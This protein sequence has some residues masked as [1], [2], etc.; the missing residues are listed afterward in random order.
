MFPT[1]M[2]K[3]FFILFLS[4]SFCFIGAQ[5]VVSYFRNAY[6]QGAKYII[7]KKNPEGED[8]LV[9]EESFLQV[10]FWPALIINIISFILL[11]FT[12]NSFPIN[13]ICMGLF[14]FTD[15]ITLGLVLMTKDENLGVRV[16]WLTAI[17]TLFA[18]TIGLYSNVDF[19]FLGNIL[20]WALIAFIIVSFV[21]IFVRIKGFT[22]K[23]IALIGIV[24]FVGY[25]LYDFNNLRKIRKLA[26][27]NTWNVALDCS[28]DIYLDI[29]NL[30]L[31]ILDLLSDD[32]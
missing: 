26:N 25:L 2:S 1:L 5:A 10:V 17:V 8:D 7:A 21:R 16:A 22:R 32:N 11:M 24:I 18:G 19:S 3:T 12:R 15:G 4:L 28:I 14:T 23:L 9:I 31:Q 20:F 30:F 29:I 13:M 27:F 6:K